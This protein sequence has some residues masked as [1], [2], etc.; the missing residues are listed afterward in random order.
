M[1][2]LRGEDGDG[3]PPPDKGGLPDL[4]PEWGVVVVPYDLA[5]LDREAAEFR[6]DARRKARRARWRRR[7]GLA[8]RSDGDAPPVGIPLLI[9]CIAIIAAL[10]SLFAITFTTK[11]GPDPAS[12]PTAAAPTAA[13][14]MVDLALDGT[15]GKAVRLREKLPAVILLLDG[16]SCSSLIQATAAATPAKVTVIVVDK[17]VPFVPA[18]A[19][20]LALAD[21]EQAL[22]AIYADGPD[23]DGAP[24]SVPTALLI[25]DKGTVTNTISPALSVS[26]FQTQLAKLAS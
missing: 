24:A 15:D 11:P 7:F 17:A 9:M 16:C 25:D 8:P 21:P 14:P 19:R 10:T 18:G 4:P 13:E 5:E 1:G 22:L 2:S 6:R 12:T 23:R 26:D 3:R 20:A